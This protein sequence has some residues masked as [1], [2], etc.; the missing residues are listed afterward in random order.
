MCCV[1]TATAESQDGVGER[2]A[3]K[4][5]KILKD[6]RSKFKELVGAAGRGEGGWG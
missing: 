6:C 2:G 3:L 1:A 4:V 5:E